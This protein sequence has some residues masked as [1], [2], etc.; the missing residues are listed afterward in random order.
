MGRG[1]AVGNAACFGCCRMCGED[2][3]GI[4]GRGVQSGWYLSACCFFRGVRQ[5]MN[6]PGRGWFNK[7]SL[8]TT[9][10]A[11]CRG[12]SWRGRVV[13]VVVL[14]IVAA[15]G[16]CK[17]GEEAKEVQKKSKHRAFQGDATVS[18][19]DGRSTKGGRA[20]VSE[21]PSDW[22]HEIK[23]AIG[24]E[25]HRRQLTPEMVKSWKVPRYDTMSEEERRALSEIVFYIASYP[26]VP[27]R[28]RFD[29]IRR[30]LPLEG[31]P[32]SIDDLIRF[33]PK[34]EMEDVNQAIGALPPSNAKTDLYGY[35]AQRM[36]KLEMPMEEIQSWI[37]TLELD[38]EKQHAA[39]FLRVGGR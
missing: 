17:E 32:T 13:A 20:R 22:S 7:Y 19:A 16:A 4:E 1:C 31:L 38:E 29:F 23:D 27:G 15:V 21:A 5:L 35:F 11:W 39:S 12:A 8:M 28:D 36:V 2:L 18:S 24:D 3:D 14:G 10:S 34:E 6:F 30:S 33:L 25:K 9:S 37:G 26:G